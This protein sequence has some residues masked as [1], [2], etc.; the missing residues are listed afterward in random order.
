MKRW[1]STALR[2]LLLHIHSF[3]RERLWFISGLFRGSYFHRG[4][5]WFLTFPLCRFTPAEWRHR[6]FKLE[7]F[8]T[9][10]SNTIENIPTP[11]R[12]IK[13]RGN[14]VPSPRALKFP[15]AKCRS[16]AIFNLCPVA[17]S[18]SQSITLSDKSGAKHDSCPGIFFINGTLSPYQLNLTVQRL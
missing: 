10:I 3:S 9:H 11:I 8:L 14:L 16:L 4:W 1:I 13:V 17:S 15:G 5:R 6:H 7:A 12:R 2:S 18:I